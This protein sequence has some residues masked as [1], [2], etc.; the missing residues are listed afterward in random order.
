MCIWKLSK[1]PELISP[2]TE[3]QEEKRST[4]FQS[5]Q[6]RKQGSKQAFQK[7]M[8]TKQIKLHPPISKQTKSS[9]NDQRYEG[10]T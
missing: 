2:K 10:I 4:S 3:Q 5:Y 9:R 1:S 7:D 6:K 8:P